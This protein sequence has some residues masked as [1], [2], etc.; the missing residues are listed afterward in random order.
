K[1]ISGIDKWENQI[2]NNYI[3]TNKL[4]D[5]KNPSVGIF[6]GYL[7]IPEDGV[8]QF[9][10]N[11][12]ELYVGGV[13]LINNEGEVKRHSRN[14]ASIVLNKGLHPVKFI[15]IN[16]VFGGWPQSYNGVRINYKNVNDEKYTELKP[17]NF[18]Y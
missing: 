17:E 5:Y 9:S 18:V 6:E 10:S 1:E 16:N 3:E 11:M 13:L 12:D 4:F 7:E 15:Y 14:D 8:Y 2:A